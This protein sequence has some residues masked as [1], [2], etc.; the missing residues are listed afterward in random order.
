MQIQT[1]TA[2]V[3]RRRPRRLTGGDSDGTAGFEMPTAF[4][5]NSDADSDAATVTVSRKATGDGLTGGDLRYR[6]RYSDGDPDG[7]SDG[8]KEGN[9]DGDC[10]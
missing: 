3:S 7:N 10:D 2:T 9:S 1:A 4:R 8:A 6:C 5:R